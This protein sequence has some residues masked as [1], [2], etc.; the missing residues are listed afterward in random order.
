METTL[1]RSNSSE[2]SNNVSVPSSKF[3]WIALPGRLK[4]LK[5]EASSLKLIHWTP[6]EIHLPRIYIPAICSRL[7]LCALPCSQTE[8]S[9]DIDMLTN[10]CLSQNVIALGENFICDFDVADLW[11]KLFTQKSAL[12]SQS[13]TPRVFLD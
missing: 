12:S 1:D 11:N 13:E 4:H 7:S 8:T 2:D 10:L 9:N 3:V 6:S 5:N